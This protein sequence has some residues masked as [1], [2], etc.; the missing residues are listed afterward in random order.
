[1]LRGST[2]YGTTSFLHLQKRSLTAEI[3]GFFTA[4]QKDLLPVILSFPRVKLLIAVSYSGFD[5]PRPS[6]FLLNVIA[7]SIASLAGVSMH[8]SERTSKTAKMYLR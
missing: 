2:V 7:A 6:F 3:I 8:A 5:T 4:N 1:M